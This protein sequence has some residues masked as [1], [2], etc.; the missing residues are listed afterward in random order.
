MLLGNHRQFTLT[1]NLSDHKNHLGQ[2]S[3][4]KKIL[5]LVLR[6]LHRTPQGIKVWDIMFFNKVSGDA[7]KK[8]FFETLVF[9]IPMSL[10][11]SY[12]IMI[13]SRS[14]SV[15]HILPALDYLETLLKNANS[16]ALL[17][18]C[19]IRT[20]GSVTQA[21]SWQ[22]LQGIFIHTKVWEPLMGFLS[23]VVINRR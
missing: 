2:Q 14:V 1:T 15:V 17:K 12:A 22:V 10:G 18:S 21:L 8:I 7:C 19:Q 13:G 6:F 5:E 11:I 9:G 16:Q 20:L 4:V 23:T 3:L